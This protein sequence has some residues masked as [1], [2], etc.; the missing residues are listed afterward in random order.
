[1]MKIKMKRRIGFLWL[2]ILLSG[3]TM[4]A[5]TFTKADLVL[6]FPF[7]EGSLGVLERWSIFLSVLT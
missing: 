7:D 6:Y 3:F 5:S 1:M 4:M 2:A